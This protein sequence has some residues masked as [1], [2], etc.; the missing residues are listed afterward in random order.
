[1]ETIATN[2]DKELVR[3]YMIMVETS[4]SQERKTPASKEADLTTKI[5]VIKEVD[6][7]IIKIQIIKEEEEI[8]KS[9]INTINKAVSEAEVEAAEE[10]EVEGVEI[11]PKTQQDK[12]HKISPKILQASFADFSK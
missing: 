4:N 3:F 9:L 8:S 11:T 7:I 10:V 2:L 6:L 5:Q 1:M 12:T